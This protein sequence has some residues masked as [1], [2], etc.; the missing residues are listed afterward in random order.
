[1]LRVI[2]ILFII[3]VLSCSLHAQ[4]DPINIP[5]IVT[6]VGT[7]A[8]N[9]LKLETGTRAIGMGGAHVA[10]GDGIY[11][12]PYNPASIGFVR[13]SETFFSRTNYVAGITHNVLGYATEVTATDF[14]G[15]HLFYLDSGE[16]DVT[17][18]ENPNGWGEKFKVLNLSLRGIYTK[19]NFR[20]LR[21]IFVK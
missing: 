3:S 12:A 13:G 19:N 4:V 17:T 7:C 5:D 21:F 11:A 18:V 15:F 1:M 20:S 8:G 9:W 16:M 10:M 2:K 14:I 6:K